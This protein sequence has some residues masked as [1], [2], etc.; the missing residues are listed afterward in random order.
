MSVPLI[1]VRLGT[2]DRMEAVLSAAL[3]GLRTQELDAAGLQETPVTGKRLLFAVG[4]DAYGPNPAFYEAIRWLRQNKESLTGCAAGTLQTFTPAERPPLPHSCAV[5]RQDHAPSSL[6]VYVSPT[7]TF[8][9]V[10]DSP[11]GMPTRSAFAP[12]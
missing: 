3:D 9:T 2:T 12:A 1:L 10:T 7:Y 4:M 8:A 5:K 11:A 6:T